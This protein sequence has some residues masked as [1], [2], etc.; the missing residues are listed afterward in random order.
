MLSQRTPRSDDGLSLKLPPR[1][2]SPPFDVAH[3]AQV[4]L[5]PGTSHGFL[6]VPGLYPPAWPLFGRSAEWMLDM[7]ARA[8]QRRLRR[9]PSP[10]SV[11]EP[12]SPVTPDDENSGG[13]LDL[14][15]SM[16]DEQERGDI[17]G[18]QA[19]RGRVRL[20]KNRSLVKLNSTDDLVGRR[21]EGLAAGLTRWDDAEGW[22]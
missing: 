11:S 13:F 4:T 5:I 18:D 2:P 17:D 20:R 1:E 6:Q 3:V 9:Y 7:F 22:E 10:I 8:T 16:K 21:M 19:G 12:T 15:A 14:L